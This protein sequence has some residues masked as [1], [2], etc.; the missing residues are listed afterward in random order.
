[1]YVVGDAGSPSPLTFCFSLHVAELALRI[2]ELSTGFNF[3][4]D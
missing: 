4:I 3:Y 1:M 2:P